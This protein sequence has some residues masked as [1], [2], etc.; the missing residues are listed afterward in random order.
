MHEQTVQAEKQRKDE[1]TRMLVEQEEQRKREKERRRKA[2]E[3]KRKSKDMRMLK[4]EIF[5]GFVQKGEY[6]EHILG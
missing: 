3:E 6:K 2:R 1:G 4:E 5:M